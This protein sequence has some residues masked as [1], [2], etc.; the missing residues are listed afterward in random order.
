MDY[1]KDFEEGSARTS[2]GAIFCR[3]HKGSGERLVFLHGMGATSRVWSRLV[4]Y[5]PDELDVSLIDLLGHGRSDAPRIRYTVQAQVQALK[6]FMALRGISDSYIIGNSYGGWIAAYYASQR[7]ACGGIVLEDAVGLEEFLDKE[8]GNRD[9]G[10]HKEDL[11]RSELA[12]NDNKEYVIRSMI[13]SFFADEPLTKEELGRIDVPTAIIWGEDDDVV[14]S[15]F[16][17]IF[18]ER[19]KGSQLEIIGGAGH[20]PHYTH[21]KEVSEMILKFVM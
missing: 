12:M 14:D 17:R 3:H 4:R 8:K 16:A 20:D 7:Y 5:L 6:E 11:I 18:A 1:E 2:L 9:L 10:R 21:P 13:E 19:I 15:S